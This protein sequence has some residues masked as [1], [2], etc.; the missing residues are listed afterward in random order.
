MEIGHGD[1]EQSSFP[2]DP[3]AFADHSHGVGQML[4]DMI[5]C[6]DVELT[7]GEDLLH[8]SHLDDLDAFGPRDP[9]GRLPVYFDTDYVPPMSL[10][11]VEKESPSASYI[12]DGTLFGMSFDPSPPLKSAEADEL[13]DP[14]VEAQA[15]LRP[16]TSRCVKSG[17]VL[18][19]GNRKRFTYIAPAAVED[20]VPGSKC[21]RALD[22]DAVN[23]I[24][25]Y[26]TYVFHDIRIR[27]RKCTIVSISSQ[28]RDGEENNIQLYGLG[29]TG[30]LCVSPRP[31]I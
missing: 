11:D 4:E 28:R 1:D 16:V 24:T 17:Q 22:Q 19:R 21:N 8:P 3:P 10:H 26:R 29:R 23:R 13:L 20:I 31:Q 27:I 9:F 5:N 7:L 2:E 12:Q 6:D 15:Y 25:A 14:S 18:P 30:R